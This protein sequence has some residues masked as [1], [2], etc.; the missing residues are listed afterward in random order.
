MTQDV[1][2]GRGFGKADINEAFDAL[3]EG[4]VLKIDPGEYTVEGYW[5]FSQ[6]PV[7][8]IGVGGDPAGIVLHLGQFAVEEG[9]LL[10]IE[11]L[12]L[13]GDRKDTNVI[14]MWPGSHLILKNV[15]VSAKVKTA[16][17]LFIKGAQA[18]IDTSEIRWPEDGPAMVATD[19]SRATV[20]GSIVECLQVKEHADVGLDNSQVTTGI[21][22]SDGG[23]LHA[24]NLY[25]ANP[26]WRRAIRVEN[27]GQLLADYFDLPDSGGM[28]V[29]NHSVFRVNKSNVDDFH[30][31]HVFMD[32]DATVE[33][34]G[35]TY[36]TH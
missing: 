1:L 25:L 32:Q 21:L 5:D 4:D 7:T 24:N 33:F 26:T 27:D 9:I 23:V 19:S 36:S 30:P 15:I 20:S 12:T 29:V 18:E 28:G 14:S 22:V 31:F 16:P 2:V 13:V 17:P 34:P 11:N 6:A 35:A 8:L 10:H 3:K